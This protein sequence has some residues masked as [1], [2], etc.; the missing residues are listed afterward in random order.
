MTVASVFLS[1]V[2]S[3]R[4]QRLDVHYALHCQA[5]DS[6]CVVLSV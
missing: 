2:T 1:P 5:Q 6:I 3:R 4:I